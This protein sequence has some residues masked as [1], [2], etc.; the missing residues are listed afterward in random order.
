MLTSTKLSLGTFR[1]AKSYHAINNHVKQR[2]WLTC[3]RFFTNLKE[4]VLCFFI[5]L[6]ALAYRVSSMQTMPQTKFPFLHHL[7][8]GEQ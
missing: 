8:L 7:Y 2:L 3:Q 6:H 4:I 5:I 1:Q